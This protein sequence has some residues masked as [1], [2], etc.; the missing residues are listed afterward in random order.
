MGSIGL[1]GAG[2]NQKPARRP[3]NVSI[4]TVLADSQNNQCM[5]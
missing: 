3:L 1:S 2:V 5:I 4:C